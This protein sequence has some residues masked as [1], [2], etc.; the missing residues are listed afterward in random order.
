MRAPVEVSSTGARQPSAILTGFVRIY[1][2]F[3]FVCLSRG[4]R[5]EERG[6]RRGNILQNDLTIEAALSHSLSRVEGQK[7]SR[8][9][10][11]LLWTWEASESVLEAVVGEL[12]ENG[13]LRRAFST[14]NRFTCFRL[15]HEGRR[16]ETRCIVCWFTECLLVGRPCPWGVW[17]VWRLLLLLLLL[18]VKWKKKKKKRK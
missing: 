17:V 2:W 16:A 15:S 18:Y 7:A 5:G 9:M 8:A 14:D 11:G 3:F 6:F 10:R 13:R 1:K 12:K 4:W